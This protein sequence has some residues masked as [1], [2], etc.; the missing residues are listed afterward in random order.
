MPFKE[1]DHMTDIFFWLVFIG[2]V[3]AFREHG[4]LPRG[5]VPIESHTLLHVKEKTPVWIKH[6]HRADNLWQ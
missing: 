5:K 2:T 3:S 4:Q 6:Q 1:I